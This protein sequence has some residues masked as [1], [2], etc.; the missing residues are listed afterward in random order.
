MSEPPYE[1][2]FLTG[3]C[4]VR[5]SIPYI[6]TP[7]Y[8]SNSHTGQPP[9]T[10]Q[11]PIGVNT[12]ICVNPSYGST[13]LQVSSSYRSMPHM[14]QRPCQRP[15]MSTSHTGQWSI[16]VNVPYVSTP[17]TDQPPHTGL[18]LLRINAHVS[19]AYTASV[20]QSPT[21]STGSFTRKEHFFYF[22]IVHFVLP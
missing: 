7:T 15:R 4:H 19:T 1:S 22:R 8:G 12:H 21:N 5:V 6:S 18:R 3:H 10:G 11:R 9:H 16:H 14:R 17:H 2:T 13:P 20:F